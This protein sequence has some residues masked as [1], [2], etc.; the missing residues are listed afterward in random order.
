MTSR[1]LNLLLGASVVAMG[2]CA[3]GPA[4]LPTP[5]TGPDAEVTV[6]GLYKMDNTVMQMGYA[7]P[8]LDL[9][10]YTAFMLDP[11]RVAYQ[12]DPLGRTRR[13]MG[14]E[15]NFALSARQMENF[16][17]IFH[18][19]VV[20]ALTEDEG[21]ELVGEPAPNVLR[22]NASLIDLVVRVPTEV[23]GRESVY[24]ASYGAV[25]LIVELYDSQSGEILA[26]TADRQ[27]PTRSSHELSAVE[28]SFM[29]ADVTRLF[30]H[31][32]ETMRTRLDQIREIS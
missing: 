5:V 9:S 7:K 23:S 14:G 3:S 17:E 15:S 28:N 12:K 26:L 4:P 13:T 21:Y 16:K 18:E 22:I 19:S 8:D 27:D 2:A 1:L 20:E 24:A 30:G 6:E 10:G 11:V 25:T 32:A 29:R 31:W